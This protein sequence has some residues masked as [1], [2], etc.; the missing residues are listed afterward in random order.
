MIV[1]FSKILDKIRAAGE[2]QGIKFTV[3]V[4]ISTARQTV[5]G[6][7]FPDATQTFTSRANITLHNNLS[8]TRPP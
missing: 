3:L 1:C 8:L 4:Q 2:R 5:S 6:T 7:S